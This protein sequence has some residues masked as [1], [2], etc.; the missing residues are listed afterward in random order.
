MQ[1][2]LTICVIVIPHFSNKHFLDLFL[3]AEEKK[4]ESEEEDD[5]MGFGLF[6]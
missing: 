6:E 4:E 3:F 2:T 5:D 1:S